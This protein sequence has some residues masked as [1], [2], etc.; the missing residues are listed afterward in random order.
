MNET[1]RTAASMI[2]AREGAGGVEVLVLER[3]TA[4]R[5]LPGYVAFPGGATDP[6]DA[7]LATT[8]FGAPGEAARACALR[9]LLEEVGLAMTAE[10]IGEAADR[11]L[12]RISEDPPAPAQLPEIAHWIAP[13]RVPVRFDARY[14]AASAPA[15]ARVVPDGVETTDA[16]WVSPGALL[17]DWRRGRRKLYWPTYFTVDAIA[18]CARVDDLLELRIR[19]REPDR[20][21]LERLPRS[22]FWQD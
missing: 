15:E 13:P 8:W 3:S 5:F 14:F 7:A 19:T 17:E 12:E 11:A 20:N 6:T 9:E 18:P 1:I 4:S 10:G 21:E 2:V 16:W 22:T